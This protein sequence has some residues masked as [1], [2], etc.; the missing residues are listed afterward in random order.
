M[1]RIFAPVLFPASRK[2]PHTGPVPL[3]D[4]PAGVPARRSRLW[5]WRNDVRLPHHGSQ[6]DLPPRRRR[7]A[8]A[9]LQYGSGLPSRHG[10]SS[11]GAPPGASGRRQ[12]GTCGQK[13]PNGAPEGVI[14]LSINA[15][16][17]SAPSDH[18]PERPDT[19]R[20][21]IP[22]GRTACVKET[23]CPDDARDPPPVAPKHRPD[24]PAPPS[25][26]APVK[27][28][29]PASKPAHRRLPPSTPPHLQPAAT[30]QAHR[31]PAPSTPAHLQPAAAKPAHRR[32]AAAT[33]AHRRPAPSTPA[34]RR[35]APSHPS[36]HAPTPQVPAPQAPTPQA[37]TPQT[38]PQQARPRRRPARSSRAASPAPP[39][40]RSLRRPC[41]ATA[42]AAA[43]TGAAACPA[44]RSPT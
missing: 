29:P 5:G 37:A 26:I 40:T 6:N 20:C 9:M 44:R 17:S 10:A 13:P 43:G 18:R 35:L 2:P 34:Y 19:T 22:R 15:A 39:P 33:Q 12:R 16:A 42:P 1:P 3:S 25:P 23:A 21:A 41:S 4:T 24:R 38:P 8:Q 27:R 7:I 36:P 28:R 31:R 30:T 11:Q 14:I 32:P